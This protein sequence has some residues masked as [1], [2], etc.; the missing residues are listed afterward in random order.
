[1]GCGAS[2]GSSASGGGLR[3]IKMKH[4]GVYDVD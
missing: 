4:V 2:K 1:M 3:D